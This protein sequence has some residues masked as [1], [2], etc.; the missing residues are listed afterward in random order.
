MQQR[1][2]GD[3][4]VRGYC[5]AA[6]WHIGYLCTFHLGAT[7]LPHLTEATCWMERTV[8]SDWLRMSPTPV[9]RTYESVWFTPFLSLPTAVPPLTV[10]V[11]FHL[12][13]SHPSCAHCG[14]TISSYNSP[15]LSVLAFFSKSSSVCHSASWTVC[16]R[17]GG[18]TLFDQIFTTFI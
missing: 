18:R 8:R 15:N 17:G 9:H 7:N 16:R 1:C 10:S 3:S 14:D 5:S 2:M 13:A 12:P 6:L 4:Y 11:S